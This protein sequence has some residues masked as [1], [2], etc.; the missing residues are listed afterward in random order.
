MPEES[1]MTPLRSGTYVLIP[2]IHERRWVRVRNCVGCG[3]GVKTQAW[4]HVPVRCYRCYETQQG[5]R[6]AT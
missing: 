1:P 4:E 3:G 2:S 5:F 6:S